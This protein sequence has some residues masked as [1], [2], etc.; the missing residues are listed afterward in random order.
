MT[1]ALLSN[2]IPIRDRVCRRSALS[3]GT[4]SIVRVLIN[5]FGYH[6]PATHAVLTANH[7]PHH[8]GNAM[9]EQILTNAGWFILIGALLLAMGLIP[10]T[11]KRLPI[12][13]AIIYLVVGIVVGPMILNLFHFNPLKQSALL[14]TLTEAAVLISLFSAGVKMPVPVNFTRWRTPILLA[15]VSMAVTV[16]LIAALGYY[17]LG[18]PLGAAVLLGAIVAPTDPVLATDV[19]IRHADD[20]DRLR[21]ILT[22]EAGINDGSAFPFVMLGLG[23]LGL[24]ELGDLGSR[25]V[26]VDVLWATSAGIVI[27]VVLGNGLGRLVWK[28]RRNRREHKLLDDFLGLGLIGLVYGLSVYVNAWGFL[29]V[30]FAAVALRQTELKLSGD[31]PEPPQRLHTGKT[32]ADNAADRTVTQSARTSEGSLIFGEHLERLSEVI[33]ILLIGGMLF[34]DSW[35]W[36]AVGFAL[37][38][39]MVARPVSILV[40]LLGTGTPWKIRGLVGWFGVRGI[41]SLYYIMFA[42]Q[43]GLPE[44]LAMQL[45]QLTLVVVTLSILVHGTSVKPL[46]GRFWRPRKNARDHE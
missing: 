39:F 32:Q 7:T 2:A 10:A 29:A 12:T 5:N 42:I 33:L 28:L 8:T 35:S 38:L 45:I 19:Q 15:V 21:F 6:N 13:S 46:M 1:T 25:W 11:L 30:F 23:L 4:D 18:L 40:G 16:G 44:K 27:G 37:F 26:V 43:H 36:Q 34:I 20:R 9:S 22:C 3:I 31:N 17:A 24:H 14:E 41:G